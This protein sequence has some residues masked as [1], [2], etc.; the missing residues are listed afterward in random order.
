MALYKYFKKNS[1]L[2]NPDGP[3]ST[4]VPPSAIAEANKKVQPLIKTD[5]ASKK[6]GKCGQY[7]VCTG[8][9]ESLRFYQKEFADRPLKESTVRTWATK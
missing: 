4:R 9:E 6:T 2:P 8:E 1:V 3:L 5:S 7:L